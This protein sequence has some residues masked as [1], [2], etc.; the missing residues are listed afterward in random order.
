MCPTDLT[1]K[2][3]EA[4]IIKEAEAGTPEEEAAEEVLVKEEVSE[5]EVTEEQEFEGVDTPEDIKKGEE[6]KYGI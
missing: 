4:E 1:E 3:E 2:E 5:E 6:K